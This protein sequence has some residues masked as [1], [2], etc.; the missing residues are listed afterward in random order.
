MKAERNVWGQLR[1]RVVRPPTDTKLACGASAGP[2]YATP[3]QRPIVKAERTYRTLWAEK[4]PCGEM[5]VGRFV[6]EQSPE[7]VLQTE[8][9]GDH[10]TAFFRARIELEKRRCAGSGSHETTG[11]V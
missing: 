7:G 8:S 1:G 4:T 10:D 11:W 3:S 5:W 9:C 6:D 2:E